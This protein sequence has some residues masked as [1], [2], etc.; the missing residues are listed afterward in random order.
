MFVCCCGTV[1]PF[2]RTKSLLFLLVGRHKLA[3][4]SDFCIP[5]LGFLFVSSETSDGPLL[6][7]LHLSCC[8]SSCSQP[9]ERQGAV[10]VVIGS[11]AISIVQTTPPRANCAR[12]TRVLFILVSRLNCRWSCVMHWPRCH[13]ADIVAKSVVVCATWQMFIS[14]DR[15]CVV[16]CAVML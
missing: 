5:D 11:L 6:L 7:P 9:R 2:V 15:A 13:S 4:Y 8:C 16:F 12:R 1:V 14:F 10:L 3:V